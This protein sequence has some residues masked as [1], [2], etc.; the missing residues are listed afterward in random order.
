MERTSNMVFMKLV[1]FLPNSY[2]SYELNMRQIN[3]ENFTV[4]G[5]RIK[6]AEVLYLEKV[7]GINPSSYKSHI[8]HTV[9]FEECTTEVGILADSFFNPE[10]HTSA[11]E[12]HA[13]QL[14]LKSRIKRRKR[15]VDLR[16]KQI[17]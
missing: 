8:D 5:Q 17:V 1:G 3:C 7:A 16:F 15:E 11:E 12:I 4:S 6:L 14:F 13:K 9:D 2:V 10:N